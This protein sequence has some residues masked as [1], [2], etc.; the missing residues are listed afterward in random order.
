[1]DRDTEIVNL[2]RNR[3]KE[4]VIDQIYSK[5]IERKKKLADSV[6]EYKYTEDKILEELKKY[7]DATYSQHYAQGKYQA[8]DTII[9][10]EY[11][12]GFCMGNMLKYWKRY[13]KKDGRN[14]KDLLK[15]IHYAMI[16]LF[17]HDSTQTK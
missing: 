14:R 4:S 11:G 13:G 17:L 16:M 6:I 7:I 1:M 15:I 2:Y 5:D 9:D 3:G 12:E 8:T 10:A